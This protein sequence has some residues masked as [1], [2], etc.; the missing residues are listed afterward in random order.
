MEIDKKK[1]LQF[2]HA[3]KVNYISILLLFRID[4]LR[5]QRSP[6]AWNSIPNDDNKPEEEVSHCLNAMDKQR[7]VG[8]VVLWGDERFDNSIVSISNGGEE[9]REDHPRWWFTK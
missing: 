3:E 6:R 9:D 4:I 7:S 5:R 2:D 1:E 8:G